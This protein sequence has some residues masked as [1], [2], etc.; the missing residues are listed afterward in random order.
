MTHKIPPALV[1]QVTQGKAVLFLGAGGSYGALLPEGERLLLGNSLRDAVAEKFLNGKFKDEPLDFVAQLSISQTS[2]GDVQNFIADKFRGIAPGDFHKLIP[3]FKW[4]GI[5]TTNYDYLIEKTYESNEDRIQRLVVFKCDEDRVDDKIRDFDSVKYLKLH[6]CVTVTNRA[7]LPFI[8]TPDQYL[9]HLKNRERLFRTFE[10]WAVENTIV[11]IGYRLRDQNLL[12]IINKLSSQLPSRPRYYFVRPNMSEEECVHWESKKISTIHLGFSDF[13]H[14]LNSRISQD[15]RSLAGL[16]KTAH[17]IEKR[18]ITNSLLKESTRK[19][20]DSFLQYIHISLPVEDGE[21]IQFY[22]G[23]SQDWYPIQMNLD[24]VRGLTEKF[25]YKEILKDESTITQLTE[26]F[27]I[28]AEAGAGKSVF[29][30]RL[31]WT[32]ATQAE[33]L[34]LYVHKS[35]Q[36]Q[37]ISTTLDEIYRLCNERIFLFI[38]DAGDNIS[39]I[40]NVIDQ[41]TQKDIK[42]S[43]ISTERINEWNMTCEDLSRRVTCEYELHKLNSQELHSLVDLLT[44]HNALGPHLSQMSYEEQVSEFEIGA[45]RQLLVALHEATTGKPFEVILADEFDNICPEA[46]KELYL[47]VCLLNRFKVPVRA[48]L[49]AR[50]HG[51]KFEDFRSD[52]F[53]PLEDVVQTKSEIGSDFCYFARHSEIAKIVFHHGLQDDDKRYERYVQVISKLNLAYDSD[54]QSFR[55]I[56]NSSSIESAF[57]NIN[58]VRKIYD[59]AEDISGDQLSYTLQQRAN[60]ERRKGG[61]LEGAIGYLKKASEID[62]NNLSIIHTYAETLRKKANVSGNEFEKYRLRQQSRIQINIILDSSTNSK[63]ANNIRYAKSTQIRLLI[64]EL[65]EKIQKNDQ[66][67]ENDLEVID[68]CLSDLKDIFPSDP[69]V[70]SL[71]ADFAKYLQD[72]ERFLESLKASFLLNPENI[73]IAIKLSNIYINKRDYQA[74]ES[75][76]HEARRNNSVDHQ[77][78][79]QIAKV[80]RYLQPDNVDLIAYYYRRSFSSYDLNPDAR[81]WYARYAF[82]SSDQEFVKESISIFKE[83]RNVQLSFEKLTE[84]RDTVR[85]NGSFVRFEG[86]V[87]QI[88]NRF[89]FVIVDRKN[90]EIFVHPNDVKSNQWNLLSFG[91]RVSFEIGFNYKGPTALSVR[92]LS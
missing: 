68:S 19:T 39:L 24:V 26:L 56:V 35:I 51:I 21:P 20:I 61:D 82:E 33:V 67:V 70:M 12:G 89:C 45:E 73:F 62:P 13:L 28:K 30:R 6:G 17:P 25:I 27:V 31:A 84:I 34:C 59:I 76:L 7:D 87:T 90:V 23:Y 77:I 5:A 3:T 22:K 9:T 64:D 14:E 85:Q 38:D 88:R 50:V 81:F 1:E 86:S 36:W 54:Y 42:L 80:T 53:S 46:A 60:Y 44:R 58:L 83:L 74:A 37:E 79:Y 55:K 4:R 49:I 10:E 15:F 41:A 18:F 91:A 29:L 63:N 48:G 92:M 8:L 40:S 66:K 32:A 69:G 65:C 78:N 2:L 71:D 75:V 47:T 72:D 43:V 57:E 52:L 11:F 16:I